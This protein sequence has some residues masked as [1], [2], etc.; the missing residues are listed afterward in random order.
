[1]TVGLLSVILV[2]LLRW[3]HVSEVPVAAL[4]VVRVNPSQGPELDVLDRLPWASLGTGHP[5]S[6]F[7]LVA[8]V[9]GFREGVDAPIVVNSRFRRCGG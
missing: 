3:G 9:D 8:A 5:A 6:E 1:M 2:L 7:S 4:V